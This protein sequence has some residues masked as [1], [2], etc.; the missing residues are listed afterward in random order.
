MAALLVLRYTQPDLARPFK[1]HSSVSE[2]HGRG[3]RLQLAQIRQ[4]AY[5][6]CARA[7]PIFIRTW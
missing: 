5:L 1:V 7:L 3:L 2:G 4:K 6:A